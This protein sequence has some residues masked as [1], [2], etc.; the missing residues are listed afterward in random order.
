MRALPRAAAP[1][2]RRPSAHEYGEEM[3]R[4]FARR[5]RDALRARR[6]RCALGA[7][8]V[9]DIA[10]QRGSRPRRPPPAGPALHGAHAAAARP[11]S[12]LT[13]SLIVALG[14]GAMTAAFSVTDYVLL[15]PLPFAD[16]DRLVQALEEQSAGATRGWSSSPPNYRDWK[17]PS[18]LVRGDGRVPRAARSTSS[19]AGEPQRLEGAAR[20][21]RPLSDC[22]ASRPALGR[23][24]S[25]RPTIAR[26]R[27]D[28]DPQPPPLA[29][30][31]SAAIPRSSAEAV[32]LDDEPY[33][34]IGVMPRDFHFP[35]ATPSSGRRCASA[36]RTTPDR[37]QQLAR[38]RRPAQRR[39]VARAGAGRDAAD[40]GAARAR[41]YPE[42]ERATP[43]SRRSPARRGVP[44]GAAAAHALCSAPRSACC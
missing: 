39:R 17:Q 10:R 27:R 18:A 26:A 14:V 31:R 3:A 21:R 30:A 15:R 28:A 33:V 16:P 23:G 41:R 11:G 37:D 8:A 12:R 35:T 22:S 7:G 9:V 42:G 19:A 2:S 6:P 29:D 1:L 38:R 5:L 44:R 20:Q 32:R 25:P 34:I 43:A 4:L 36:S 13:A 24:S 40:R